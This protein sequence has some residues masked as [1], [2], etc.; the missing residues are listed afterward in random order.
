MENK[1]AEGYNNVFQ[2]GMQ[3]ETKDFYF[4]DLYKN[5]LE[6][7]CFLIKVHTLIP[8]LKK[9]RQVDNRVSEAQSTKMVE[10][11]PTYVSQHL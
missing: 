1:Q 3:K 8:A 6:T 7:R 9:K 5:F 10:Q 2:V 11:C 4:Y